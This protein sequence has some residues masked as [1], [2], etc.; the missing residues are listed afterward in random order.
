MVPVDGLFLDIVA[1]QDCSCPRCRA[2]MEQQGIDPSVARARQDFGREVTHR[3]QRDLT[4][5]IRALGRD[6]TIFYNGGHIGPEQ[7]RIAPRLHPLGAGVAAQ[8]RLGLPP[9]P[10]L[11]ALRAHA[12]PR[13]PGHDRASSTRPG[14]TST[15]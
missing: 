12:R 7:R 9:L 8:R 15:P 1:G 3:F 6:G 10:R 13:L 5:F 14:A 2:E 4:A 11:A